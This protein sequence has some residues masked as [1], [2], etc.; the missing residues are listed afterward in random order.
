MNRPLEM[1]KYWFKDRCSCFVIPVNG[2]T[3][4]DQ[5]TRE[6][7]RAFSP[8]I[9]H[10][11]ETRPYHHPLIGSFSSREAN[12]S[13]YPGRRKPPIRRWWS[14]SHID[15][16]VGWCGTRARR[17]NHSAALRQAWRE[18]TREP[19][20]HA[21]TMARSRAAAAEKFT[22]TVATCLVYRFIIDFQSYLENWKINVLLISIWTFTIYWRVL[23]S[24]RFHNTHTNTRMNSSSQ[25]SMRTNRF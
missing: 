2:K 18:S 3:G 17:T 14:A 24:V 23:V 7:S 13:R 22:R 6:E 19:L 21:G 8:V 5:S 25:F 12:Q 16:W 20:N 11:P 4:I 10:T 9:G 15:R 1:S